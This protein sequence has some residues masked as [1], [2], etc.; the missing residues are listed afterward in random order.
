MKVVFIHENKF[1]PAF[2]LVVAMFVPQN[3][4]AKT[5]AEIFDAV[6]RAL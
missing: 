5:A 6:H 1:I 3:I 2:L 4:W